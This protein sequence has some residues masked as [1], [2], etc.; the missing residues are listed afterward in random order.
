MLFIVDYASNRGD[1]W[2]CAASIGCDLRGKDLDGKHHSGSQEV[3]C[4]GKA[5]GQASQEDRGALVAFDSA[6]PL[7]PHLA[8][9]ARGSR[10]A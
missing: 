1:A 5:M 7:H 6:S 8:A 9:R 3:P 2:A 4:R 10:M